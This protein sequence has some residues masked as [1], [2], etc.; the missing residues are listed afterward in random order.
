MGMTTQDADSIINN[1]LASQN[2]AGGAA[3]TV[4]PESV[5]MPGPLPTDVSAADA[6]AAKPTESKEDAKIRKAQEDLLGKEAAKK[7]QDEQEAE[8]ERQKTL[9]G[10]AER[11]LQSGKDA[12]ST[13]NV[14]IGGIPTPGNLVVP[15]VLLML[16]F[17]IL[18][19]FNGH[20]RLQWAWL[21]LTNN[22]YITPSIQTGQTTGQTGNSGPDI[23]TTESAMSAINVASARGSGMYGEPYS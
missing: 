10:L 12:A 18:I 9:I 4:L 8:A 7:L 6:T 17:F 11:A 23:P 21:V 19:T 16:F 3:T 14:K 15:L 22:A 5:L 20:T 2:T 1:A 13:A